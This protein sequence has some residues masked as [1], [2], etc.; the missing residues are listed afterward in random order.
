[1][2]TTSKGLNKLL[3]CFLATMLLMS[4]SVALVPVYAA[5]SANTSEPTRELPA[6]ALDKQVEDQSQNE[7]NTDT[8]NLTTQQ[9]VVQAL[10]QLIP[11][12][13]QNGKKQ[14]PEWLRTI[15]INL[16][17]AEDFKPLYSL[18]TLQPFTK[19]IVDGKLG[20]WQGRYANQSGANNTANLGIGLRWLSED[21][22]SITG[23]NGFYDYA[24]KHDLSRVGIGAEYFNKQ[25]EYRANF[26][27][28][29]SDDRLTGTTDL[30][31]GMLY[32]YI[33]AVSGFDFEV[34]TSLA[35]APWLS[36][37]A[38]GF[39]YD[40]KHK[41]DE[42]GYKL[43]SK[44]QLTPKL[45]MEMGY[46][47]SNLTS[48]SLYGKVLYQWADTAGPALRGGNAEATSNDISYKL[49][50]KVQR[51]NDIKTETFTKA[52]K[53]APTPQ[54]G[55]VTITVTDYNTNELIS[56]ATVSVTVN[57]QVIT[58]TTDEE[59]IAAFTQIPAGYYTFE[60]TKA[61]YGNSSSSTKVVEGETITIPLIRASGQV[62]ITVNGTDG[63]PI[64]GVTVS[65]LVYGV[66]ITKTTDD[67]GIALFTEL[68]TEIYQ[69]TATKS[70]YDS[71]TTGDIIVVGSSQKAT[72]ITLSL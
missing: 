38:S 59:G 9:K 30:A 6:I 51:E 42:N 48:G 15:D 64:S 63:Q 31:D 71:M 47:N 29:T 25:A 66:T 4:T 5:A 2:F 35:N 12:Y 11:Y 33:R 41:S 8:A 18:E 55:G 34:G 70:G 56:D 24:F 50:Q 23:I 26:Y 22:T 69:F 72:T 67:K 65:T 19:E 13:T 58:K 36:F 57:G 53:I 37:Y 32:S 46:S 52:A 16:T 49:L 54:G 28:P 20:F 61:G 10:N 45:S 39:Q 21:K 44:M 27:I 43:R 62:T 40:N 68:P 1:M 7:Q 3:A 17:F 60:V 14:G